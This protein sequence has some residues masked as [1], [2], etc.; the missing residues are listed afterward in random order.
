MAR[1]RV[2]ECGASSASPLRR[3]M[4]VVLIAGFLFSALESCTDQ[5]SHQGVCILE[6]VI[7]NTT[8]GDREA[9]C[10]LCHSFVDC[11]AWT[12]HIDTTVCFTA[13]KVTPHGV[14]GPTI[15]SGVHPAPPTPA[16]APIPA[17]PLPSFGYR[18]HIVFVLT[19]D[20]DTNLHSMLALPKTTALLSTCPSCSNFT[21]SF[22][23]TPIW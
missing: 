14:T 17:P 11:V 7:K 5:L 13:N 10:S 8:G 6:N 22:V 1:F 19:D 9:C 15:I 12:F 3:S 23:A 2:F 21:N 4:S 16:P 20:Q 18:P